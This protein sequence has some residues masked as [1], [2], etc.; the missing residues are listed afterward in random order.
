MRVEQARAATYA[1]AAIL[2]DSRAG[3]AVRAASTAKLLAS[4]AGIANGRTAVQVLGGMGFTWEMLPHYLLKRSWV[5]AGWFGTG[6]EHALRLA[7]A[8][9]AEVTAR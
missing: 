7:D 4:E 2:D 8:L 6:D 1:A 5:L 9:A 3:D